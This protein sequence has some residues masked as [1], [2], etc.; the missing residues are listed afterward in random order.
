MEEV[1]AEAGPADRRQSA[2]LPAATPRWRTWR[3]WRWR[4]SVPHPLAGAMAA[5]VLVLVGGLGG[6]LLKA[7]ERPETR[8]VAAVV[9]RERLPEA[10]AKL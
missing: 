5:A 7:E 1:A 6:W 9:D 3:G 8:T 10:S 4:P 2:A